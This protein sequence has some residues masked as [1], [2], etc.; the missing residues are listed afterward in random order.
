MPTHREHRK[1]ARLLLGKDYPDI[2]MLLDL[3]AFMGVKKHRRFFHD[4]MS[5]FMIGYVRHGV[6]GGLAG[7]IHIMLDNASKDKRTLKLMK[8]LLER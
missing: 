8:A 2:D 1:V 7:L 5:A 3:P 4:P 6:K